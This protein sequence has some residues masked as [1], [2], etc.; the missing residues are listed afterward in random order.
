MRSLDC[1]YAIE[2]IKIAER[3][4]SFF[5]IKLVYSSK[6]TINSAVALGHE[7]LRNQQKALTFL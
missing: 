3:I 4:T 5:I 1:E 7:S 2:E 6:D